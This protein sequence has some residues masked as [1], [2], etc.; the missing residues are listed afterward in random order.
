VSYGGKTTSA[1][2]SKAC[3][4]DLNCHQAVYIE[5]D[6]T[7]FR[8]TKNTEAVSGLQP[9]ATTLRCAGA[10]IP[11]TKICQVHRFKAFKAPAEANRLNLAG[12]KYGD[13]VK[14]EQE[15]FEPCA[16]GAPCME[17]VYSSK[18]KKCFPSKKPG[19]H[20]QT[21]GTEGDYSV[22]QCAEEGTAQKQ[23]KVEKKPDETKKEDKK[24][25]K[26][27]A[28]AEAKKVQ[29]PVATPQK[30]KKAE[31]A[32]KQALKAAQA[33]EKEKAAALAREVAAKAAAKKKEAELAGKKKA[34]EVE[35][36]KAVKKAEKEKTGK[37]LKAATEKKEKAV[38]KMKRLAAEG[39][40][41]K[42]E[43]ER[44]QKKVA[45]AAAAK[46]KAKKELEFAKAAQEKRNK[47]DKWYQK[48]H[49]LFAQGVKYQGLLE[50]YS[51]ASN[52]LDAYHYR[53]ELDSYTRAFPDGFTEPLRDAEAKPGKSTPAGVHYA[54]KPGSV[55]ALRGGRHNKY[56][57]DSKSGV[58]CKASQIKKDEMFTVMK[59]GDGKIAL[60][61]GRGKNLCANEGNKIVCN[62]KKLGKLE[63]FQVTSEDGYFTFQ[64]AETNRYCADEGHRVKCNRAH[65]KQWEKFS[66]KCVKNC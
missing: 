62:S 10:P 17:T 33:I 3:S 11:K 12:K 51:A 13:S 2:C 46:E 15:C 38:E 52:K 39:K 29:K 28:K 59:V 45:A 65:A 1:K 48:G 35:A 6:Q 14:S 42:E 58:Q 24:V 19:F 53:K 54:L 30:A 63:S 55:V 26:E 5:A 47:S 49:L 36:K 56:C 18:D 23:P 57:S 4:L 20:G 25:K 22:L 32:D 60:K 37:A 34:A 64:A 50:K 16:M 8:T 66:V 27:K 9:G 40:E 31:L 21:P 7:C 41:K 43:K 61:G 44:S